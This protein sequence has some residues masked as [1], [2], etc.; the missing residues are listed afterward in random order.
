MRGEVEG[1]DIS[2]AMSPRLVFVWE[3]LLFNL[4]PSFRS[5][6]RK[7]IKRGKWDKAL[8]LWEEDLDFR[9]LLHDLMWRKSKP[10]DLLF[11]DHP[12]KFGYVTSVRLSDLNYPFNRIYAFRDF[13]LAYSPEV[14][15]VFYPGKYGPF[16]FGS[17]GARVENIG[18]VQQVLAG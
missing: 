1:G 3:H 15:V 2:S 17:K 11:L 4:D 13:N 7:L 16:L 5:K 6:E 8:K 9:T 18:D 14:E 12:P 10:V